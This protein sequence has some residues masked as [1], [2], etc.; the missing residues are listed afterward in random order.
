ME[1]SERHFDFLVI[2]FAK[3]FVSLILFSEYLI[4]LSLNDSLKITIKIKMDFSLIICET[5]KNVSFGVQSNPWP[6]KLFN[7]TKSKI[8]LI[9]CSFERV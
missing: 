1:K 9:I 4:L 3:I 5:K 2:W 8:V 7:S 6:K